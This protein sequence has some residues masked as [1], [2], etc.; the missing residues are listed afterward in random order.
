MAFITHLKRIEYHH[1]KTVPQKLTLL[2]NSFLWLYLFLSLLSIISLLSL[3][4]FTSG[5][6]TLLLLLFTSSWYIVIIWTHVVIVIII[7]RDV[8][9][10]WR[11]R[12]IQLSTPQ[13]TKNI[14]DSKD[15]PSSARSRFFITSNLPSFVVSR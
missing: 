10:S 12:I 7:V 4:L 3:L 6:G 1:K 13:P 9:I 2:R 5:F 11:C 8:I 14:A 15:P